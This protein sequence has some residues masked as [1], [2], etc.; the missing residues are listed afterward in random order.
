MLM[1]AL[2]PIGLLALRC[3]DALATRFGDLLFVLII[4]TLVAQPAA[5]PAA[6][7]SHPA[8]DCCS[9]CCSSRC[10]SYRSSLFLL[11]EI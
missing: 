4:G 7:R 11:L 10:S 5:P 6:R 9:T 1:L 3:V 2:L 8:R